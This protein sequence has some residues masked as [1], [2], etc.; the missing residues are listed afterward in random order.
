MGNKVILLIDDDE[1]FHE[2]FSV[3]LESEGFK[4]ET[5]K[6]AADGIKKAKELKP[7]LILLDVRMPD[8]DG[9]EAIMKMKEDSDTKNLKI[10]FITSAGDPRGEGEKVDSDVAVS[11]GALGF[12]RKSE[13][14]SEVV[15]EVKNYISK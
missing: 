13:D 8:M 5:A 6:S 1:Y 3:K 10:V 7:D 2:I 4:V 14:L 9:V 11:S 15:K 12:I